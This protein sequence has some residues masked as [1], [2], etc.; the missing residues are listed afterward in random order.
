MVLLLNAEA[1]LREKGPSSTDGGLFVRMRSIGGGEKAACNPY[2]QPAV[3]KGSEGDWLALF[4]Q[5]YSELRRRIE[6]F[7]DISIEP[8]D[9]PS[10]KKRLDEIG[11]IGTPAEK[12]N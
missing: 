8:L 4:R 7:V 2:S 9:R 1:G 6:L 3:F 10:L 5:T 12:E 11:K